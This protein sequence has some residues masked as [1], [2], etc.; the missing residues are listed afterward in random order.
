[1]SVYYCNACSVL[2]KIK[3]SLLIGS[4][5]ACF[6]PCF[7]I[8]CLLLKLDSLPSPISPVIACCLHRLHKPPLLSQLILS[9]PIYYWLILNLPPACLQLCWSLHLDPSLALSSAFHFFWFYCNQPFGFSCSFSPF[10]VTFNSVA[11]LIF[12]T[13]TSVYYSFPSFLCCYSYHRFI[14]SSSPFV[15]ESSVHIL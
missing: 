14:V 2:P 4:S 5:A 6:C 3:L 1:M 12:P 7:C 9:R 8:Y 11:F 15:L 10:P 13:S